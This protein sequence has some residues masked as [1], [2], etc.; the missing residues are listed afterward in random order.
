[1]PC[2][3][4]LISSRKGLQPVTKVNSLPLSRSKVVLG[5]SGSLYVAMFIMFLMSTSKC[6]IIERRMIELLLLLFVVVAAVFIERFGREKGS[7]QL[8]LYWLRV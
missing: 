1:M 7:V 3:N 8:L 2:S 5:K 4:L 6:A